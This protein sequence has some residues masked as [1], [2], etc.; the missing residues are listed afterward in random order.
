[1]AII[2]DKSDIGVT[3]GAGNSTSVMPLGMCGAG[4]VVIIRTRTAPS[5]RAVVVAKR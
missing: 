5:L 2:V 4:V 3:N 1:M